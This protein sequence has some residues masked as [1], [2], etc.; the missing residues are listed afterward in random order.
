MEEV[1]KKIIP[2]LLV[3]SIVSLFGAMWRFESVAG[4]VGKIKDEIKNHYTKKEEFVIVKNDLG[5][6]MQKQEKISDKIDI[7]LQ[8]VKRN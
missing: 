3:A 2:T 5:H 8:A 6:I 4:E 1:I 7:I